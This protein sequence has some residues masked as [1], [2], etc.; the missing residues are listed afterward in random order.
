MIAH[1]K[2][3]HRFP[4]GYQKVI[5]DERCTLIR[6]TS[7]GNPQYRRPDGETITLH[8]PTTASQRKAGSRSRREWLREWGWMFRKGRK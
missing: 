4:I 3:N 7:A 1:A 5:Q 8:K 6:Y 2:T